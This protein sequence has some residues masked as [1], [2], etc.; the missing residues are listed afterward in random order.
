MAKETLSMRKK[1]KKK[2]KLATGHM[3]KI[4]KLYKTEFYLNHWIILVEEGLC[5]ST[6]PIF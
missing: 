1:R 6:D 3:L 5:T 4:N 2:K